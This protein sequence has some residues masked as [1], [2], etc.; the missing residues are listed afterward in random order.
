QVTQTAGRATENS[1][2]SKQSAAAYL[3]EVGRQSQ[4][5]TPAANAEL[6]SGVDGAVC[7]VA[8]FCAVDLGCVDRYLSGSSEEGVVER[9]ALSLS[10]LSSPDTVRISIGVEQ[11]AALIDTGAAVAMIRESVVNRLS[12]YV[13]VLRIKPVVVTCANGTARIVR[14]ECVIRCYVGEPRSEVLLPML[15]IRELSYPIILGRAA[16]RILGARLIYTEEEEAAAS[17]RKQLQEFWSCD[18]S[19]SVNTVAAVEVTAAPVIELAHVEAT[20]HEDEYRVNPS[21]QTKADDESK[22]SSRNLSSVTS[23]D[24]FDA[25][26]VRVLDGLPSDDNFLDAALQRIYDHGI[27]E[28]PNAQS[29]Q[30]SSKKLCEIADPNG[31]VVKD[32]HDQQYRFL[33]DWPLSSTDQQEK[34]QSR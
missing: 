23:R 19:S 34:Q 7:S 28:I 8:L 29:Y 33:V 5:T 21:E 6:R 20:V 14:K 16:L 9:D 24:P 12:T 25:E 15:V 31:C 10:L 32:T 1:S 22:E 27:F 18:E 30:L 3:V 4:A 2:S 26:I 17:L 13:K 11:F